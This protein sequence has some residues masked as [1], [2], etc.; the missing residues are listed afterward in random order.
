MDKRKKDEK[1]QKMFQE[2]E[3]VILIFL[4][5]ELIHRHFFTTS[6]FLAI[7]YLKILCKI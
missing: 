1:N 7:Q 2:M 6:V 5:Q 3:K 4:L